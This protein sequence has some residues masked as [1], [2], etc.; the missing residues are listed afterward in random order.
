MD[1]YWNIWSLNG[2]MMREPI[3]RYVWEE[4]EKQI[5]TLDDKFHVFFALPVYYNS[6]VF[7]A[8]WSHCG[9]NII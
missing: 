3:V 2:L 5:N 8:G 4:I 6:V 1:I 7:K 9:A